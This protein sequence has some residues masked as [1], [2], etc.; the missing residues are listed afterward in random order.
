ML[1]KPF[2]PPLLKQV[3]NLQPPPS[4]HSIVGPPTKRR[5]IDVDSQQEDHIKIPNSSP[6]TLLK[7]TQT[8][9]T[10]IKISESSGAGCNVES[11][12]GE[13]YYNV[14]W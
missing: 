4:D 13:A 5:R 9:K 7:S 14:L 3:G 12:E 8:F 11:R 1:D 2:R 10:P 6:A